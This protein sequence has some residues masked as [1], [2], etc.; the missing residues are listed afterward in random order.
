MFLSAKKRKEHFFAPELVFSDKFSSVIC[1]FL[2][3]LLRCTKKYLSVH[4]QVHVYTPTSPYVIIAF[5][6][7]HVLSP[8][9]YGIPGRRNFMR[10][11]GC[12]SALFVT[13][14]RSNLP[15]NIDS[16]CAIF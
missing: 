6:S 3:A 15:A 14:S 12:K 16:T 8:L 7:S 10:A 9:Q 11:S 1:L 2:R 13:E 5:A 4:V